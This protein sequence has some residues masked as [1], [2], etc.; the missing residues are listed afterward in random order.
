MPEV[1]SEHEALQSALDGM[2]SVVADQT[3]RIRKLEAAL[4]DIRSKAR[5]ELDHPTELHATCLHLIWKTSEDAL[6]E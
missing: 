3:R 4:K 1:M 2:T 6:K 5:F